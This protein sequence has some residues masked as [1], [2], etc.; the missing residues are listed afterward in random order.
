MK[1][2]KK[3]SFLPDL[4]AIPETIKQRA[5]LMVLNYPNSPTGAVAPRSFWEEAVDF[6][7]REKLVL[8]ND[9]AHTLLAYDE[10]TSFLQVPGA[11]DVGL[12]IH[13]MSKGFNMIGW[14]LGFVAGNA[15][16]VQAL[17]DVKDN[18]DSGQFKAIQKAACVALS[19]PEIHGEIRKKYRRRLA[20]RTAAVTEAGFEAE[21]PGG[22]YFL[23][24]PVPAS[25]QGKRFS[26]AEE[27]GE[28]ILRNRLVLTVPWDDAGAY[29]RFSTTYRA[30]TV[31]EEDRLMEELKRR[32][33]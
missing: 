10:L 25:F 29:L 14:R 6:A 18:S 13:S 33:A 30:D 7:R 21:M 19:H 2:E 3:H 4:D 5:K 22:T 8:V 12:E 1:L 16:L 26:T 27:A 9:A 31:E 32:L 17:A 20:K 11:M 24:V 23:Y 15:L 28:H